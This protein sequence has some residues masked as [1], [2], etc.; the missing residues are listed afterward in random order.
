MLTISKPLPQARPRPTTRRSSLQRSRII[1]R[2]VASSRANGKAVWP[3]S[4]GL[5]GAVSAEDFAKLSRANIH[6]RRA[7]VRQQRRMNI[8]T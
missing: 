8:R 7:V 2:S 3:G 6:R 5:V 1:G 4:F